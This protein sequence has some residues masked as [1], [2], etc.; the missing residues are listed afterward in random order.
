MRT[1]QI[2]TLQGL[3]RV[4]FAFWTTTGPRM[5]EASVTIDYGPARELTLE[6]AAEWPPNDDYTEAVF[7]E[8][9]RSVASLTDKRFGGRFTLERI[10][11]H[12]VHSSKLAFQLATREAVRSLFSMSQLIEYRDGL[13]TK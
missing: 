12:D 4:T 9:R 1:V 7:E 10:E 3:K 6:S 13:Y 8:I 11:F 5:I 2:Y